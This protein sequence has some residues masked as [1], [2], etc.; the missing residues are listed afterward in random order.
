MNADSGHDRCWGGRLGGGT[1]RH[2]RGALPSSH[3]FHKLLHAARLNRQ[4]V[5][6]WG[7]NRY[8]LPE[9]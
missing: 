5:Q 3:P 4:Q 2:R 9:R 6:A 8:S 7:V 1:S